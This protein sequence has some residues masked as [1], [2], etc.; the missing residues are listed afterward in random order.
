MKHS[1]TI[2]KSEMPRPDKALITCK[3]ELFSDATTE[4]ACCSNT[5]DSQ[6][7][8]YPDKTITQGTLNTF[9]SDLK[10]R[11]QVFIEKYKKE[12]RIDAK[13]ALPA[14]VLEVDSEIS[15]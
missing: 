13:K 11:V 9:K 6:I 5:F 7:D 2:Q 8:I 4:P 15:L 10:N 1:L 14:A 12:K 3:L